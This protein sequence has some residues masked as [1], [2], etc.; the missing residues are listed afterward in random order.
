MILKKIFHEFGI[1]NIRVFIHDENE[2]NG[3]YSNPN[4]GWNEYEIDESRYRISENYKIGLKKVNPICNN[5][6]MKFFTD[7]F[8]KCSFYLSDL[9][10]ILRRNPER[11]KLFALV[12]E[13]TYERI[14]LE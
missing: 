6:E 5:P 11:A 2:T 14:I 12:D 9:G 7:H 1:P 13:N 3:F 8:D 10:A 4:F